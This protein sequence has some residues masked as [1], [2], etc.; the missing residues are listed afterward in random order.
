MQTFGTIA[1][2]A[3]EAVYPH[4]W[5]G[6]RLGVCPAVGVTG[7]TVRDLSGRKNNGTLQV[8][9]AANA[10]QQAHNGWAISQSGATGERV[11]F[12]EM[13]LA[14]FSV[15]NWVWLNTKPGQ[16][17]VVAGGPVSHYS[18]AVIGTSLYW[19]AGG[20]YGLIAHNMSTGRW[21]HLLSSR[22]GS[23]I[24]AYVDGQPIGT[25]TVTE[26]IKLSAIGNYSLAGSIYA[27]D[28]YLGSQ[29]IHDRPS[30]AADAKLLHNLGPGS[31]WLARKRRRV[32]SIPS[33]A[34]VYGQRI[35]RHRTIL[36]GGLR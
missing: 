15:S 22:N 26:T 34:I 32:Y 14:D 1:Q 11:Q 19:R 3:S 36:G 25:V 6:L 35:P 30:T 33:G 12:T 13:Q 2:N 18:P 8:V 4:L 23:T 24:S 17:S 28:G 9:T 7:E 5:K 16:G 31:G 27:V 10:W 21:S 29:L 20:A